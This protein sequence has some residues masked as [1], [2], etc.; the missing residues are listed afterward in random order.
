MVAPAEV[1]RT[2]PEEAGSYIVKAEAAVGPDIR[3]LAAL[4]E[5]NYMSAMSCAIPFCT[6]STYVGDIVRCLGRGPCSQ[7]SGK[8]CP[9]M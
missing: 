1:S 7:S 6:G 4:C 9:G 8:D 3:I 2:G 5:E